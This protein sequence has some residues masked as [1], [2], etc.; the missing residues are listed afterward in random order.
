MTYDPFLSE[1]MQAGHG[2]LL[3]DSSEQPGLMFDCLMTKRSLLEARKEEFRAVAR[4]WDAAVRYVEAHPDEA[5]EIMARHLGGGLD[6]P[7]AFAATLKGV[8]LYDAAA[9][10]AFF[11]TPDQPGPIYQ[12]MQLAIDVLSDAGQLKTELTPADLII[13]GI[14]DE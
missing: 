10:R 11:G 6:D 4:A 14:F 1:A 5:N 7:A 12:T 13:H 2:H 8:S 3:T 9:N